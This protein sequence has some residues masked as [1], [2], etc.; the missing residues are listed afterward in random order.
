MPNYLYLD[1]N[2]QKQGPINDQQLKT[3]AA[4]GIITPDTPLATDSGHK[5]KAG[6]IP[7]LQFKTAAASPFVQP[8]QATP[9]SVSAPVASGSTI[10]AWAIVAGV[11]CLLVVG[12]LAGSMMSS[13]SSAPTGQTTNEQVAAVPMNELQARNT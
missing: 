13:N 5:G 2:G 6:Q 3:L 8:A 9:Q 11:A 1:A 7:G 4:Q 10:P 12:I